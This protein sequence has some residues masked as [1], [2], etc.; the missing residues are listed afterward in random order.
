MTEEEA[1]AAGATARCKDGTYTMNPKPAQVCGRR[2]G[3]EK[4]Y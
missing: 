2:G 1:K 3:I 4:T